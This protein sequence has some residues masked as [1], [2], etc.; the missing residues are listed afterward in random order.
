MP[1]SQE[2][3]HCPTRPDGT[4]VLIAHSIDPATCEERQ[5]RHYHKCF[6]CV[7]HARGL[8]GN[9]RKTD[10]RMV[11]LPPLRPDARAASPPSEVHVPVA[12]G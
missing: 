10:L 5:G 11:P 6:S 7:H 4:E 12:A 9:G 2:R 1:P 3:R 8:N